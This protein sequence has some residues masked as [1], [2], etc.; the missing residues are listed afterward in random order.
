MR[1]DNCTMKPAPL[2]EYTP[3]PWKYYAGTDDDCNPKPCDWRTFKSVGYY[4][5]PKLIGA[6][7]AEVVGCDEYN[8]F[9]KAD[10]PL[11]AAAPDMLEALQIASVSCGFKQLNTA[12]QK[13]ILA[14]IAKATEVSNA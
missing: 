8:V 3:G 2:P 11:I 14:A 12:A 13:L 7:G 5:N 10:M 1:D 6:N 9:N 4:G